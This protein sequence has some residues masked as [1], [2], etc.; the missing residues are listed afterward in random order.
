MS[1][2]AGFFFL[3]SMFC[4]S[5]SSLTVAAFR[6]SHLF[7]LGLTDEQTQQPDF[8]QP[9]GP[10]PPSSLHSDWSSFSRYLSLCLSPSRL[11]PS[12]RSLADGAAGERPLAP[13]RYRRDPVTMETLGLAPPLLWTLPPSDMSMCR[14]LSLFPD[15]IIPMSIIEAPN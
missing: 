2:A 4:L 12:R 15:Q 13:Q 11:A 1:P 8:I 14:G 7:S 9:S 5:V 10:L 3:A 6:N